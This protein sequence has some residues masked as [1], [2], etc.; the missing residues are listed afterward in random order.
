[1][2]VRF[3]SIDRS[4]PYLLPPSIDDWLPESHLARFVSDVVMQLD[5]SEI[6]NFY[7]VING[8]QW[9]LD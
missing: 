9:G 6:E 8:N 1:M 5:T 3:R 2:A 7:S 4:T